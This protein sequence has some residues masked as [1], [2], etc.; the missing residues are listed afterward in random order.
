MHCFLSDSV[1]LVDKIFLFLGQPA[2]HPFF[3]LQLGVAAGLLGVRIG[4]GVLISYAFALI[5]AYF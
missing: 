3:V 2:F 5:L 1:D 4:R